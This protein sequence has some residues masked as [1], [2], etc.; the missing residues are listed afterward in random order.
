MPGMYEGILF[1]KINYQGFT[2]SVDDILPPTAQRYYYYVFSQFQLSG[3][4]VD[5]LRLNTT[6]VLS[7][8][9]L[10]DIMLNDWKHQ[11]EI[12]DILNSPLLLQRRLLP[13]A[14]SPS[15]RWAMCWSWSFREKC[16]IVLWVY[17]GCCFLLNFIV[18]TQFSINTVCLPWAFN[19]SDKHEH[20]WGP[21]DCRWRWG[22]RSNE[23]CVS[24]NCICVTWYMSLHIDGWEKSTYSWSLLFTTVCW[25]Y[26][27]DCE[28]KP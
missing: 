21:C 18:I 15:V 23:Q 2:L 4:D 1:R 20:L 19:V 27:I 26:S 6:H 10:Q 5:S 12:K 28:D 13:G 25:F 3:L 22:Q 9:L 7:V 17:F 11:T 14:W 8:R 16:S 24:M